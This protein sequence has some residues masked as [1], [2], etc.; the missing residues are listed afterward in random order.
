MKRFFFCIAFIIA[1]ALP[2]F[3]HARA[4]KVLLQYRQD[5]GETFKY[6]MEVDGAL[7]FEQ[8]SGWVKGEK[9]K[10]KTIAMRKGFD[11]SAEVVSRS[12][13]QMDVVYRFGKCFREETRGGKTR[14]K[15]I[16]LGGED[17]KIKMWPDGRTEV[18]NI[19][20]LEKA[21]RKNKTPYVEEP[22]L[23]VLPGK[24]V[25][26]GATWKQKV[27]RRGLFLQGEPVTY[28]IRY[29]LARIE[30]YEGARCAVIEGYGKLKLKD[31]QA[32][33][34]KGK[35]VV[36]EKAVEEMNSV[37]YFDIEQ[38]TPIE[39]RRTITRNEVREW[40][41]KGGKEPYKDELKTDVKITVSLVGAEKK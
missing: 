17:I 12:D 38:G 33:T 2:V 24:P 41:A 39:I 26:V 13:E 28:K 5:V 7:T 14:K 36:I 40:E 23:T 15:E 20:A 19:G 29:K 16:D 10:P 11:S 1:V 8:L 32:A 27:T 9:G 34:R 18:E 3:T 4:E 21:Y 6:R 25:K 22:F 31:Y 35:K 37:I 30:E